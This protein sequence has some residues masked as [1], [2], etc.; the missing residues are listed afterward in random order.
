MVEEEGRNPG[1]AAP[2]GRRA[3]G[4]CGR[5]GQCLT[6][7]LTFRDGRR[8]KDR[9]AM[10]KRTLMFAAA[11]LALLAMPLSPASAAPAAQA[12]MSVTQFDGNW[13][14]SVITDAGTCDRGYRYALRIA[15]G[16]IYYDN[17]N[18]DVS[19]QVNARG[20]VQ[21]VVR[22]GGQQAVGYG[23]MSRDY[24]EGLWRGSSAASSCSGHWEAERR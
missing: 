13:S 19:G 3:D 17:P 23:R 6:N 1:R 20:Q 12:A 4:D 10:H 8:N 24:G 14:V 5:L 15:A 18:I 22:A 2:E 9:T 16:R 11:A 21:V 7:A